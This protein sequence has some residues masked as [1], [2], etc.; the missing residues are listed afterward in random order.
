MVSVA[1]LAPAWAYCLVCEIDYMPDGSLAR[2][3]RC[4]LRQRP[5]RVSSVARAS[6]P[7]QISRHSLS[8]ISRTEQYVKRKL[9]ELLRTHG[10]LALGLESRQPSFLRKKQIVLRG[11]APRSAGYQPAALLLSYRTAI[12]CGSGSRTHLHEFMRLTSVRWS[13]FP[14]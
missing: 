1:G 14:Q 6:P 4:E 8:S 11:N 9:L 7:C 2:W 10:H 3:L 12:G 5:L 13:S